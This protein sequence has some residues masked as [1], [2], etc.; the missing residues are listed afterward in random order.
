ME[1]GRF[2]GHKLA[3]P[4]HPHRHAIGVPIGR[5]GEEQ[6]TENEHRGELEAVDRPPDEAEDR[7]QAD[8]KQPGLQE[9]PRGRHALASA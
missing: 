4:D 9:V 5:P 7:A 3:S 2:P 6:R 1:C 8:E